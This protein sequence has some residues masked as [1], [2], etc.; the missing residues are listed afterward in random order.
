MN[1]QEQMEDGYTACKECGKPLPRARMKKG[2]LETQRQ[3]AAFAA[4]TIGL[5]RY[6]Y[7]AKFPTP[8]GSYPPVRRRNHGR[9]T[10]LRPLMSWWQE[11]AQSKFIR[12]SE[13]HEVKVS[14]KLLPEEAN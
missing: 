1:N 9:W 14:R 12:Q 10:D 11:D 6:C 7:R 4:R 2:G 8:K 5:C 13:A 3:F